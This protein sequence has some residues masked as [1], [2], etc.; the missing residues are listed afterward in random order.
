MKKV[1][2]FDELETAVLLP[3]ELVGTGW[4]VL[5]I[6]GVV[7][8]GEVGLVG[9]SFLH[10]QIPYLD[11]LKERVEESFFEIEVG[12]VPLAYELARAAVGL[13]GEEVT[14]VDSD[15]GSLPL[16]LHPVLILVT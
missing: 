2:D 11:L 6:Q 8:F 3:Q 7:G 4:G 5:A 9:G 13:H 16:P 1:G 15:L 10:C 14:L 12:K